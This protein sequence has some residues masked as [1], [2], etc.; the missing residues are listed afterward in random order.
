MA[1][2]PRLEQA[3]GQVAV[4]RGPI[5]YCLESTDLPEGVAV[6]A[7]CLPRDAEWT[8]RPE[9]DLLGGVTVLETEAL[10]VPQLDPQGPLYQELPT[11]EPCPVPIRMIPYF[12]WNNRGEPQMTVWIPLEQALNAEGDRQ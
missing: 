5:V 6:D 1:A 12:A 3:R 7:I 2:D 11:G 8:T 4:M 10:A 9:P